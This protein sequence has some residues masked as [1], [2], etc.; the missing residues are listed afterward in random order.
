M[1]AKNIPVVVEG[2]ASPL[3]SSPE[4]L[5]PGRSDDLGVFP[6]RATLRSRQDNSHPDRP[7]IRSFIESVWL[8]AQTRVWI[9]DPFFGQDPLPYDV[10][11]ALKLTEAKDL[12]LFTR[13]VSTA[14]FHEIQ[15]ERKERGFSAPT[16]GVSWYG[17]LVAERFPFC[18]D[19]FAVIDEELWHF[20][21]TVGGGQS[22]LTA[23]SRGWPAEST[24]VASFFDQV[25]RECE[26]ERSWR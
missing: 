7:P 24:G 10:G 19:R 3:A 5:W 4:L 8:K 1:A 15:D 21:G 13:K 2:S 6:D 18:H 12:R 23:V 22:G 11:E 9:L 20:G 16:F 17:G 26:R 14:L 25:W